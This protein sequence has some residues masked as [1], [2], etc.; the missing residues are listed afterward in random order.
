MVVFDD[1]NTTLMKVDHDHFHM[2]GNFT[3]PNFD[4]CFIEIEFFENK[5]ID[6]L[7]EKFKEESLD[8]DYLKSVESQMEFVQNICNTNKEVMTCPHCNWVFPK[9]V[10]KVFDRPKRKKIF[11]EK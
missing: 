11:K 7:I 9:D 8:K 4:I 5:I 6:I 1:N 10:V 2:V 3:K